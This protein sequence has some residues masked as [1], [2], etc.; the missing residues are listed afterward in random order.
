M[1]KVGVCTLEGM[2]NRRLSGFWGSRLPVSISLYE[3]MVHSEREDRDEMLERI[4]R[5]FSTRAGAFK[6]TYSCRFQRF[7]EMTVAVIRRELTDGSALRVHDVGASDGRT[8]YEFF[9]L[10]SALAGKTL[11]FLATDYL[12]FV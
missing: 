1:I 6:R 9:L 12:P 2:S 7:D 10:L 8:S 4:L 11:R 5:D 3:E